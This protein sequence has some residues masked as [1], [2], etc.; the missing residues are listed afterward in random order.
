MCISDYKIFSASFSKKHL[1]GRAVSREEITHNMT[2]IYQLQ[3]LGDCDN[4]PHFNIYYLL[5]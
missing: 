4:M 1:I 3:T 5:L 2:V